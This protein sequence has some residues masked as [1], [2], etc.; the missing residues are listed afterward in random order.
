[1]HPLPAGKGRGRG[2]RHAAPRSS[3]DPPA[4]PATPSPGASTT[5]S[6]TP[7]AGSAAAGDP[8]R[9]STL[10]P[11][12]GARPPLARRTS[13]TAGVKTVHLVNTTAPLEASV[14]PEVLAHAERKAL[15]AGL[16]KCGVHL[17]E[18]YPT[19]RLAQLLDLYREKGRC[20]P[21]LTVHVCNGLGN[22]MRALASA[23]SVAAASGRHLHVVW[24]P[25]QHCDAAFD[26]VLPGVSPPPPPPARRAHVFVG[27]G[28]I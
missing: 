4:S 1:M 10:P 14:P 26:E 13:R 20:R 12:A 17:L 3:L 23:C 18:N 19:P 5:L 16:T 9:P 8:P 22:R 15:Y 21:V 28:P 6:R 25:D 2:P 27:E 24:G 11:S 7:R